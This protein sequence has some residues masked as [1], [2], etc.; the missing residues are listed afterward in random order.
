M[1]VVYEKIGDDKIK[2]LKMKN[3]FPALE[4]DI[5]WKTVWSNISTKEIMEINYSRVTILLTRKDLN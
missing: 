3:D 5:E 2:P 4:G 1:S